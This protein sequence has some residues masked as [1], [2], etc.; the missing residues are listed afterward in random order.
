MS[1]ICNNC[2]CEIEE[3]SNFC[4]YCG[5][6]G[7]YDTANVQQTVCADNMQN[8]QMQADVWNMQ[9]AASIMQQNQH[10]APKVKNGALTKA[11]LTIS[12]FNFINLILH[13][14]SYYKPIVFTEADYG[15]YVLKIAL[16]FVIYKI[17][18]KNVDKYFYCVV[19]KLLK[20]T[21][22]LDAI[23]LTISVPRCGLKEISYVIIFLVFL[24][25]IIDSLLF[26]ELVYLAGK[27]NAD[28]T[29]K[30]VNRL[31]H[32]IQGFWIINIAVLFCFTVAYFDR[33]IVFMFA[34]YIL[35]FVRF[36][37]ELIII[38]AAINDM[39]V[40][41]GTDHPV[42]EF[43]FSGKLHGLVRRSIPNHF[44]IFLRI[45]LAC[46]FVAVV[47][48]GR[49]LY[50]SFDDDEY[51]AYL[52]E[53]NHY[54]TVEPTEE[55]HIY[56]YHV[57]N[58]MPEWT[59]LKRE[60]QGFYNFKTGYDSGPIYKPELNF[61]SEGVSWNGKEYIDENGQTKIKVPFL[62]RMTASQRQHVIRDYTKF[63]FDEFHQLEF[64]FNDLKTLEEEH[65]HDFS[66][67]MGANKIFCNGVVRI[68][69]DYF[70]GYGFLRED[71]T[72]AVMPV[73]PEFRNG[74]YYGLASFR[75]THGNIGV[76]NA[77][78]DVLLKDS[79]SVERWRRESDY[80]L[81]NSGG[82][83]LYN[84]FQE[85]Y[86]PKDGH[87]NLYH[88]MDQYGNKWEGFYTSES[89][90]VLHKYVGEPNLL[91]GN[92]Y[93]VPGEYTTLLVIDGEVKLETDKYDDFYVGK[94]SDTGEIT[95]I[96]G[97]TKSGEEE[98]LNLDLN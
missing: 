60:W 38:K 59:G 63:C 23:E 26:A 9:A 76:I 7:T 21:M 10:V 62:V 41:S 90:Y 69:S 36:I 29:K 98:V 67:Y 68:Y 53:K 64:C 50:Y 16:Y 4:Q 25:V 65:K 66:S 75:D 74:S 88:L 20:T 48:W 22:I 91:H 84:N 78:G 5:A 34:G 43:S 54:S 89:D 35:L 19:F 37:F 96:I 77:S 27:A 79:Y 24:K 94:D 56:Y 1:M 12:I 3:G 83:V 95:E 93:E 51:K 15:L 72:I 2:G 28:P 55:Y 52:A 49:H 47:I 61:E 32:L 30:D 44:K 13:F 18:E 39:S 92:T 57:S 97:K 46:I 40:C 80:F 70:D 33:N 58:K 6:G 42:V 81:I 17:L 71:G 11:F 14:A 31:K 82:V 73:Y 8:G 45:G 86:S 87:D 85:F